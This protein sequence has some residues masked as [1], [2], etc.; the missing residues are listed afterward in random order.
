M[1]AC[2]PGPCKR[3]IWQRARRHKENVRKVRPLSGRDLAL[4]QSD[5]GFCPATDAGMRGAQW[6]RRATSSAPP[7]RRRFR[8][9]FKPP[10]KVRLRSAWIRSRFLH[11]EWWIVS[12]ADGATS[13]SSGHWRRVIDFRSDRLH[14]FLL[15]QPTALNGR[16][17]DASRTKSCACF[18]RGNLWSPKPSG[19]GYAQT[20]DPMESS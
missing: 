9:D 16:R 12:L 19:T 1:A 10:G 11:R 2:A 20:N 15:I 18:D 8:S 7:S 4:P 6:V 14:R 5:C 3:S 13:G 17:G